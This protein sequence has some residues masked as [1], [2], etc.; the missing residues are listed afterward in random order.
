M[1]MQIKKIVVYHRDGR[2]REINFKLSQVNIITGNSSTGKTTLI[3][4]IDYCLGGSEYRVKIRNEVSVNIAAYGVLYQFS[5]RQIFIAKKVTQAK[6]RSTLFFLEAINIELPELEQIEDN[7]SDDDIRNYLTS[8]VKMPENEVDP[9]SNFSKYSA[10]IR[11]TLFYVFLD[12]PTDKTFLFYKQ[13]SSQ[14]ERTI[15]DT[16]PVVLLAVQPNYVSLQKQLR[17]K[18]AEQRALKAEI[19]NANNININGL[20]LVPGLLQEAQELGL[21][22]TNEYSDNPTNGREILVRLLER[23]VPNVSEVADNSALI[24][25]QQRHRELEQEYAIEQAK[26]AEYQAYS[27]E[28]TQ[29]QRLATEHDHRLS[30]IDYFDGEEANDHSKTC[31]I[32]GSQVEGYNPDVSDLQAARRHIRQ[33]L[34]TVEI[35]RPV[36]TEVID[37]LQ[38]RIRLLRQDI[39]QVNVDIE[40]VLDARRQVKDF[41]LPRQRIARFFGSINMYL[42]LAPTPTDPLADLQR[43]QFRI[44][45]EIEEL[46]FAIENAEGAE[47]LASAILEISSYMTEY[48][49]QIGEEYRGAF[50]RFDLTKL[51]AFISQRGDIREFGRNLGSDKNYLQLHL[52]LYLALHRY[53]VEHNC[54][55]PR[56]IVIDQVDR[57]FY[58]DDVNYG[59][60]VTENPENLMADPDRQALMEI[61]DLFAHVCKT[62][63]IQIIVLQHANFPDQAYQDSVIEN[64]RDGEALIPSDWIQIEK[65]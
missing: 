56:F 12:E 25:L 43:E 54:P 36:L 31:P 17:Q 32:C 50:F 8:L 26:L 65:D 51:T 22:T 41:P 48:G 58:P 52:V 34:R 57:P 60:M 63:S 29:Y 16:M 46:Q 5:D 42:R 1:T 45:N 6:S 20:T 27:Q 44:E 35:K 64:W 49:S 62:L 39:R 3:D 13:G 38:L 40:T 33:Q 53:F 24:D 28:T 30:F 47:K 37:A 21:L 23:G 59:E 61:F 9:G 4:I 19:D 14:I 10:N 2:T 15:K 55:A 11:H 7:S 18:K